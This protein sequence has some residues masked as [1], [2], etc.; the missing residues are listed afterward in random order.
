MRRKND[1]KPKRYL[2]LAKSVGLTSM[3]TNMNSDENH[4]TY[5]TLAEKLIDA[6]SAH[7]L[8]NDDVG[9]FAL[10]GIS[11]EGADGLANITFF[12]KGKQRCA[13]VPICRLRSESV[14]AEII[15]RLES[16]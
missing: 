3:E 16:Y 8:P 1:K 13:A 9:D 12:A 7:F 6:L 15:E 4:E 11:K 10:S 2:Q 14:V 5:T